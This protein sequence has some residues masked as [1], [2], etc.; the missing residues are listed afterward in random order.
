MPDVKLLN[1]KSM[2]F[3]NCI[4]AEATIGSIDFIVSIGSTVSIGS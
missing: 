1:V 3:D 4:F 2:L